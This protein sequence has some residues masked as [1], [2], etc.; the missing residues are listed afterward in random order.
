MLTFPPNNGVCKIKDERLS[1]YIMEQSPP[2]LHHTLSLKI[3]NIP[4]SIITLS[5]Q[6]QLCLIF[7][8][9]SVSVFIYIITTTQPTHQINNKTYEYAPDN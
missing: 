7:I 3:I 2:Q 5:Q 9:N 6:F 1:M 4:R 8:L